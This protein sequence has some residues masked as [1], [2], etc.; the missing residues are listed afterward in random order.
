MTIKEATAMARLRDL[1]LILTDEMVLARDTLWRGG[2]RNAAWAFDD[3]ISQE[4]YYRLFKSKALAD[5]ECFSVKGV[6]GV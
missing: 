2:F 4:G 5:A 3:R 6:N 1:S